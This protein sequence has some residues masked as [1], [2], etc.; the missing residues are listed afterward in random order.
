[1]ILEFKC[2]TCGKKFIPD[3]QG[4][5]YSKKGESILLKCPN[6]CQKD[7][8]KWNVKDVQFGAKNFQATVSF[9]LQDGTRFENRGYTESAVGITLDREV[10]YPQK[11]LSDQLRPLLD[12]Y[13]E[14]R[15]KWNAQIEFVEAFEGNYITVVAS[16]LKEGLRIPYRAR[17]DGSLWIHPDSAPIPPQIQQQID[18]KWNSK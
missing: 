1:M 11:H 15:D 18:E 4:V 5:E 14:E 13:R 7:L 8:K 17:N 16:A 9:E 2:N 12:K 6:C 3:S 10:N